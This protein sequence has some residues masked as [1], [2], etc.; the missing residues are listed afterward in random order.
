MEKFQKHFI[1]LVQKLVNTYTDIFDEYTVRSI[2]KS[3]D[4]ILKDDFKKYTI[5]SDPK[6]L[7][8]KCFTFRYMVQWY[9]HI[10]SYKDL[11]LNEDMKIFEK[12]ELLIDLPINF[13]LINK[14][15]YQT[16]DHI[17]SILTY[18]KVMLVY[19]EELI[20]EIK[21]SHKNKKYIERNRA[22]FQEKLTPI[23]QKIINMFGKEA[24]NDSMDK[25]VEH[26]Y[27]KINRNKHKFMNGKLDVNDI[28]PLVESCY[29]DIVD[30]Y[31]NGEYSKD[32]LKS[33]LK[34]IIKNII[35]SSDVESE[36]YM[37]MV[38]NVIKIFSKESD[39]D[40]PEVSKDNIKDQYKNLL[41]K[42]EKE[43]LDADLEL[44]K[45]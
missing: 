34:I 29:N 3:I 7:S 35:S 13:V 22:I 26:T 45:I 8:L 41:E 18:L 27:K 32:E 36:E 9:D 2:I 15:K 43:D 19:C 23:K 14:S 37:G 6:D 24:Y 11:I 33:S 44:H 38:N 40:L 1:E 25:I 16:Q 12:K 20:K 28:R 21:L 17:K 42:L 4:P 31:N 39:E 30:K 5:K 10:N